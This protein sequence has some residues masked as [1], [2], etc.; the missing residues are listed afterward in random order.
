LRHAAAER[1][2]LQ[3]ELA[4]CGAKLAALEQGA[5]SMSG[6]RMALAQRLEALQ[7]ENAELRAAAN[8]A[9]AAARMLAGNPAAAATVPTPN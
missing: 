2:R 8:E 7:A 5:E 3:R 6:T 4:D 9:Q 1:Q